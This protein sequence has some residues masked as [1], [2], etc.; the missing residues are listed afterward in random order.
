M[1]RV[2]RELRVPIALAILLGI[3]AVTGCTLGSNE[4]NAKIGT[5]QV[6]AKV[7]KGKLTG[8]PLPP[9][10]PDNNFVAIGAPIKLAVDGGELKSAATLRTSIPDTLPAGIAPEMIGYLTKLEPSGVWLWMGGDYDPATRT[11][12]LQTSHFSEWMLGY[13]DPEQLLADAQ[14]I[15]Y[16]SFVSKPLLEAMYGK[17]PKVKC[18]KTGKTPKSLEHIQTLVDVELDD[19]EQPGLK[20][21]MGIDESTGNYNLEIAN[22]H[23]YPIRLKLPEGVT[24]KHDLTEDIGL[25]QHAYALAQTG[26]EYA[27]VLFMQSK[28]RLEVIPEKLNNGSVIVGKLDLHAFVFDTVMWLTDLL[29]TQRSLEKAQGADD[30]KTR[31]K[32]AESYAQQIKLYYK[33][34]KCVNEVVEQA[35][36]DDKLIAGHMAYT[37]LDKC[38]GTAADI[39]AEGISRVSKHPPKE[40]LKGLASLWS[41]RLEILKSAMQEGREIAGTLPKAIEQVKSGYK[42]KIRPTRDVHFERA[43]PEAGES[44]FGYPQWSDGGYRKLSAD[45]QVY[46]ED[47]LPP[48]CTHGLVFSTSWMQGSRVAIGQ[49]G[50][51]GDDA[52]FMLVPIKP[53]HESKAE[54]YLYGAKRKCYFDPARTGMGDLT[55]LKTKA[56]GHTSLAYRF[57][58]PTDVYYRK[59]AYSNGYLLVGTVGTDNDAESQRLLERAF[60]FAALRADYSLLGTRFKQ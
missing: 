6:T 46:L 29:K 31:A 4:R 32:I 59:W 8:Q 54:T 39:V 11:V 47:T 16:R 15:S 26:S 58:S 14:D 25:P 21:C 51:G 12:T 1:I 13:T 44:V 35:L 24:V 5:T 3:L 52:W 9:A 56:F 20:A 22:P 43:L 53:D 41:T 19:P 45:A 27:G 38:F 60:E 28:V 48:D 36:D 17:T 40:V 57:N 7:T 55:R 10:E 18:S 49:Y 2:P 30:P 34:G 42:V 23:M 33:H 37:V 50:I